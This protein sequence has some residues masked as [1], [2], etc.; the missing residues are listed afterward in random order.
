MHDRSNANWAINKRTS[1]ASC[2]KL[3]V[4]KRNILHIKFVS[5]YWLLVFLTSLQA[6]QALETGFRACA[7]YAMSLIWQLAFKLEIVALV[8]PSPR[9]QRQ[10]ALPYPIQSTT[11]LWQV[12]HLNNR[13]YSYVFLWHTLASQQHFNDTH[14]PLLY[15]LVHIFPPAVSF[16]FIFLLVAWPGSFV[17]R[18]ARETSTM[19][20]V[21]PHAQC[22]VYAVYCGSL[23]TCSSRLV[24]AVAARSLC[25]ATFSIFTCVYLIIYALGKCRPPGSCIN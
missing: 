3:F 23:R 25:S 8:W 16:H 21:H 19:H 20:P 4:R 11:N 9:R 1:N 13:T 14:Y 24:A 5:P 15:M 12:C 17:Q 7:R 10:V 2:K 6:L 22:H 18:G